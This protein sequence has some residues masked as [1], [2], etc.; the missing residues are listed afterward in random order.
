M[1][2]E[3]SRKRYEYL[4]VSRLLETL[5]AVWCSASLWLQLI[6]IEVEGRQSFQVGRL[7]LSLCLYISTAARTKKR[8]NHHTAEAKFS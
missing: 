7:Y 1:H 6:C 3:K 8:H 4:R 5:D 2:E